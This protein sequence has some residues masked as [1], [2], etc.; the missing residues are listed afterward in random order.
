MGQMFLFG[1]QIQLDRLEKMGDQLIEINKII[2]SEIFRKPL[3]SALRKTDYKKG[4]RPPWD[5]I[6]MFK[7]LMLISWYKLSYKKAQYQVN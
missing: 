2:N 4:G 6:I 5:V 1:S 7:I 3:E